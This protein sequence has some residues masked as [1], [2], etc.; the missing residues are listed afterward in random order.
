MIAFTSS[1]LRDEKKNNEKESRLCHTD[2]QDVYILP[3]R[4]TDIMHRSPP[5]DGL[6]LSKITIILQ[7]E[8][9]KVEVIS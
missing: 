9:D 1:N 3:L 7:K 2:I 5:W 8:L 6:R 4:Y